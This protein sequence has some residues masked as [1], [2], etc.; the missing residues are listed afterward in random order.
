MRLRHR[1]KGFK[2]RRNCSCRSECRRT[3][4]GYR[5]NHLS[6]CKEEELLDRWL[7]ILEGDVHVTL[8][9]WHAAHDPQLLATAVRR[10]L[11]L[12]QGGSPR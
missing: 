8:D 12:I 4:S 11:C 7:S 10:F 6:V 1:F 2:L 9:D 5:S 3:I